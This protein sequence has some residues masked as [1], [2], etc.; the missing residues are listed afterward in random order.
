MSKRVI[1]IS[2]LYRC[3]SKV[4]AGVE[5]WRKSEVVNGCAEGVF[6]LKDWRLLAP[7]GASKGYDGTVYVHKAFQIKLASLCACLFRISFVKIYRQRR[8]IM[9]GRKVDWYGWALKVLNM[10]EVRILIEFKTI[11]LV[12]CL[13]H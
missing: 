2:D 5:R 4:R 3:E 11:I 12:T 10:I 8:R 9:L 6:K 1:Y 13:I 7:I